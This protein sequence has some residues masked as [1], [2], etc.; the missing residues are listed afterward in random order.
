MARRRRGAPGRSL[1]CFPTDRAAYGRLSQLISLGQRR[2]EKGQCRLWLE[3]LLDHAE[4]QILV[5]L[6]PDGLDDGFR[7]F[8]KKLRHR[9]PGRYL[10][11]QHLYRGDDAARIEALAALA[12]RCRMPLV[13]TGD[14]L[15]H[16]PERRPLQDVL[17]CIREHTTIDQAGFLLE[18]NAERHLKPPA[19]MARLFRHHPDALAR[20]LEIADACRF[21]LDELRYD[22][23][24][25]PAPAGLTV[26]QHLEQLTW[27]GAAR[28]YPDGVPDKV[29]AQLAHEFALIA[30]L[31]YAPYF[32]TVHDI[33]RFARERASSARA[34]ARPP[35]PRS[36]SASASPRSTPAASIS[37]SSASS[38]PSATSRPTSMSTSS[39]SGARR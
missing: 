37:C 27:Q 20:S 14:V 32:L 18:A 33:V 26:Q 11:A 10:A 5:A 22:Y 17:S 31:D 24:I 21:S 39:T 4:G 1:L 3:D 28:R 35:T 29:R 15:Y 2:A 38:R 30:G 13:A 23:P 9:L 7:G 8:L 16:V 6:P 34:A 19:E 25:D 12:A 36:A